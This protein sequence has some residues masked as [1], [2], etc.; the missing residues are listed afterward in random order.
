MC[1]L[2]IFDV[3][4]CGILEHAQLKAVLTKTKWWQTKG[5]IASAEHQTRI[6]CNYSNTASGYLLLGQHYHCP[7]HSPHRRPSMWRP[8][9][10][11]PLIHSSVVQIPSSYIVI[12]CIGRYLQHI[13]FLLA[14]SPSPHIN[15]DTPPQ[16]H[17]H[18]G[19]GT[20]RVYHQNMQCSS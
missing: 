8:P 18:I 11:T 7:P 13:I 2:P 20:Y 14:P 9:R 12:L 5:R 17:L 10:P 4:V 16:P 15:F 19:I 1:K 6:L 3:I